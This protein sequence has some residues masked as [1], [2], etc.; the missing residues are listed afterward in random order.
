MHLR[1]RHPHCIHPHVLSFVRPPADTT[2]PRPTSP[3]A[4]NSYLATDSSGILAMWPKRVIR[5]A[6]RMCISRGAPV[7]AH[8]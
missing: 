2:P 6:V 7:A 8:I 4:N 3:S 5:T 1:S